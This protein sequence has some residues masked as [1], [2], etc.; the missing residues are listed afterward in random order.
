[1]L[2]F[3]PNKWYTYAL[4]NKSESK[5]Y[6]GIHRQTKFGGDYIHSSVNRHLTEDIAAGYIT[7]YIVYEGD[8][9]EKAHALET[10]FINLCKKLKLFSYNGNSGGGFKGGA[11]LNI[12]TEEDKSIGENM[13]Y[14]QKYPDEK[15]LDEE[16][17]NQKMFELSEQCRK[18]VTE[19]WN[20]KEGKQYSITRK[21]HW[22]N[23]EEILELP[24]EQVRDEA[25]DEDNVNEV[26]ESMLADK[27]NAKYE[28]EAVTI[29]NK[30]DQRVRIDGTSTCNAVYNLDILRKEN[31]FGGKVPVC[32]YDYEE[33]LFKK[34]YMKIYGRL[35]N[36]PVKIKKSNN[37]GVLKKAIKEFHEENKDLFGYDKRGFRQR[38]LKLNAR[39]FSDGAMRKAIDRY[40]EKTEEQ[41]LQ[42]DN[43]IVYTKV[44][45]ED[46]ESDIAKK[47][48]TENTTLVSMAGLP[49][50]CVGNCSNL[51]GNGAG[52][53]KAVIVGYHSSAETE[54]KHSFYYNKM[55]NTLY[56]A[57]WERD[58]SKDINGC[59]AFYNKHRDTTIYYVCLPSRY[60][61]S[62]FGGMTNNIIRSLF[63][64]KESIAA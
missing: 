43:W 54:D 61:T 13:L 36:R 40:I 16:S 62:Q 32:Y 47:F 53:K 10:H 31:F 24:F 25:V 27:A 26:M 56:A 21:V 57:C 35:R 23:V 58:P 17:V 30:F 20:E 48:K 22:V 49:N 3:E 9:E 6:F 15:Y 1:M 45:K 41:S 8:S 38:F 64:D 37:S 7:S 11:R 50:D 34:S 4:V 5:F 39:S 12:L 19:Y 29:V 28:I 44:M 42:G 51:F 18:A 60:D 55:V 59:S 2:F 52:N 46:I 14:H 63:E 33:F